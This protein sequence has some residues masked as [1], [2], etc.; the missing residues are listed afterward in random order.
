M[1]FSLLTNHQKYGESAANVLRFFCGRYYLPVKVGSF[2]IFSA[3]ILSGVL[4]NICPPINP[5][6]KTK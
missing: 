5:C 3:G 4:A 6:K 2:M 1:L